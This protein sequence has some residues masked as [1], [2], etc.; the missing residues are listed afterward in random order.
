MLLLQLKPPSSHPHENIQFIWALRS[1]NNNN[2]EYV[3]TLSLVDG[4]LPSL[5]FRCQPPCY[6]PAEHNILPIPGG[7]MAK[8]SPIP[9]GDLPTHLER[10]IMMM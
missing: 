8:E 1:K 6:L 3:Q 7:G 10:Q 5:T 9:P 2:D 4:P